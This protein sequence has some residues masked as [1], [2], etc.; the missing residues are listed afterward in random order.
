[1]DYINFEAVVKIIVL[2]SS[3]LAIVFGFGVVWRVERKLDI[4]FKLFLLAIILFLVSEAAGF[5]YFSRDNFLIYIA[6]VSK[7]L[8]ALFFLAGMVTMRN[9][10][11]RIDGEK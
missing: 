1:M 7:I 10:V 4:S 9:M 3:L 6:P 2:A 5:F 8:F 11:R